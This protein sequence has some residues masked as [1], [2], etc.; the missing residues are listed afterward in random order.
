MPTRS[1]RSDPDYS[2][3]ADLRLLDLDKKVL[4]KN[5]SV[6]NWLSRPPSLWPPTTTGRR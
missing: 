5:L 6:Q 3:N 4:E 2:G 1:P